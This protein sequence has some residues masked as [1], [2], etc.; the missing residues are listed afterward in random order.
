MNSV[1]Q[2]LFMMPELRNSLCSAPLPASI[3]SSGGVVSARGADL[4]DRK[5][6]MQW[7]NGQSY[8]AIVEAFNDTSGMHTIRYCKIPVA[9]A[10]GSTHQ[11]V[12]HEYVDI[13]PPLIADEFFLSEGRPGKETG[14]FEILPSKD[15]RE[16][17]IIGSASQGK[18]DEEIKETEDEST[19]RHL[20]EEVQ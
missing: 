18:P 7:E 11:Q 4:V 20:M 19:S 3:R 1:L 6:A 12:H 8:D 16:E 2:Q 14:V 17:Q 9:T 5:V 10:G 13:L 15:T